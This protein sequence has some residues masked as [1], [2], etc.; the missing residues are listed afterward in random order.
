M[1]QFL[2]FLS[3]LAVGILDLNPQNE[4]LPTLLSARRVSSHSKGE[5]S[6]TFLQFSDLH[7]SSDNLA[8]VVEFNKAYAE[9]IDEA[10]HLG[11]VVAGYFDNPNPWDQVP[12]AREIINIVGNHDCWKGYKVWAQTNH[13]YDATLEDAY[14]KILVGADRQHPFIDGWDVKQPEGVKKKNSKHYCACYFYKDYDNVRLVVLDG[15]HYFEAQDE[16]FNA[17]LSDAAKKGK[18]VIAAVH[19]PPQPGV[20]LIESGFSSSLEY[21]G[22]VPD[23]GESQMER[24][25]DA[26]Y[27]AVDKFIAQGG[28]FACWMSGHTHVDVIG[29][30]IGHEKQLQVIVDKGGAKDIYMEEDRTIGTKNQDAFNLLTVNTSKHLVVIQRIGCTRDEKMRSKKLFC[31]DYLSGEVIVNE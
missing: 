14:Y 29:H 1:T 8:R 13:P 19:F 21:L 22:P 6:V 28:S 27:K 3:L 17:T 16:W 24:T 2:T 26:A 18:T 31:F 15:L 12:G 23:P 25:P 10:I 30:V 4:V 9:Y 7:G 11:D 20:K 5:V